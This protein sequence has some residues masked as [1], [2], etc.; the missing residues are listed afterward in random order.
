MAQRGR[1]KGSKNKKT[2]AAARS[3]AAERQRSKNVIW[4][5]VLILTG[6]L[7]FVLLVVS[8]KG[9]LG[10]AIQSG[11]LFLFSWVMYFLPALFIYIGLLLAVQKT[12]KYIAMRFWFSLLAIFIFAAVVFILKAG[13]EDIVEVWNLDKVNAVGFGIG[14]VFTKAL[15]RIGGLIALFLVLAGA[16]M[17]SA[18]ITVIN[19][20]NWLRNLFTVG[21]DE[22]DEEE[23]EEPV[24]ASG[25]TAAEPAA[26]Q[27]KKKR[28]A[29]DIPIPDGPI[30]AP[31]LTI[32]EPSPKP[33]IRIDDIISKANAPAA[34]AEAPKQT[35]APEE[36][37]KQSPSESKPEE[38]PADKPAEATEGGYVFPPL[39]LLKKGV[40]GVSE[41]VS[42]EMKE[43]A[44]KLV[45]TLRSFGVPTTISEVCRGPSVTRY[46][47]QPEAG[48]KVS[49]ITGLSDDLA[50]S[51]AASSVRIEAPIPN[52]AAVGIEVPNKTR[53]TVFLRDLLETKG[54]ADSHSRLTIAMGKGVSG[55][56]IIAD[57][58]SM[59]HMLIAGA[60][61]S[62]KSI[63]EN[64]IIM[65]IIYKASP[66]EVKFIMIDPKA[67]ELTVYNGLPHL[68]IPVVTDPKRAAGAL[69][70]A[71]REMMRRYKLLS[72]SGC[73]D[74][75]SYNLRVKDD[76]NAEPLPQYVIV[77]D[78]LANLMMT[79]PKEVED[80]ICK[81][82]Q[83][84]RAAGMHLVIATQRPSVDV[85][86]GLI[87]ANIPTRVALSVTSQVDSRTI[88]DHA[89][90]EKLLGRGDMLYAPIDASKAQR[91][92]GCFVSEDEVRSVV[93]FT[94]KKVAAHYDES[95]N[96]AIDAYSA[97][98][99]DKGGASGGGVGDDGGEAD[100]M[101]EAAIGIAVETQTISTSLLQRRLK[102]GYARAAR[103][104]DEMEARGIVGPFEGSKPR[105]VLLTREQWMEMKNRQ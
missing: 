1:P 23:E 27:E 74:I 39:S 5:T 6:V 38:K 7:L 92:Q 61:G 68:A 94:K 26:K 37:Y 19:V 12:K 41:D 31:D 33:E 86:T 90:A 48:V 36:A 97:N 58:A 21:V 53:S 3:A 55:D 40:G 47:L 54:F 72:E 32:A 9:F 8:D 28:S 20:F 103:I 14:F 56:P 29:I 24:K 49:R 11:M 85:I 25:K 64:C 98:Q 81:L 95:I 43:N 84:A 51:L 77:I 62:G 66:D 45:R 70:W 73:R 82:A 83:L 42:N 99:K 30:T 91:V 75:K 63:C 15:G 13:G 17:M 57:L 104:V 22:D 50:L 105:Q 69:D 35:A 59:P 2:I 76:E 44:D 80:S 100:E 79:S 102:L 60:T 4:S 78:E 93:E 18:G 96:E 71:V 34:S 46:E 89:G 65:S 67:V 10:D 101:L 52:K 87:K 88:I 16:L